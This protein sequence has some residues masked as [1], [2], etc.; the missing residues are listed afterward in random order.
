M[1][2]ATT[3]FDTLSLSLGF[4]QADAYWQALRATFVA[5][6]RVRY[7]GQFTGAQCKLPCGDLVEVRGKR[8]PF[9]DLCREL[10]RLDY[11]DHRIQ[12]FTPTG[13]PSLKGKGSVLAG[14]M[15]EESDKRGLRLRKFKPFP[16][17]GAAAQCDLGP[18][19]TE[20]PENEQTRLSESP[21]GRK[22]A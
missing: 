21:H 9:Y 13:T 7:R 20:P 4:S 6:E 17:G 5:D 2:V 10:D 12:I 8:T 19:G 1:V 22:A 15:V 14:L 11:G 16:V 3:L 18:E